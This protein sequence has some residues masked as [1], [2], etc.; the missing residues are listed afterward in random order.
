MYVSAQR[1]KWNNKA[2]T[3]IGRSQNQVKIG[4]AMFSLQTLKFF[5]H[6]LSQ[7]AQAFQFFK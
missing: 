2:K 3:I 1:Q 6:T 5:L 4:R 7:L